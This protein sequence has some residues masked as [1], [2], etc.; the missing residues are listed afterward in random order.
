MKG[1]RAT[2]GRSH[3]S[4][5]MWYDLVCK[6][7]TGKLLGLTHFWPWEMDK[8]LR[9]L[10]HKHEDLNFT[11]IHG[12][13]GMVAPTVGWTMGTGEST[14]MNGSGN[15][16]SVVANNRVCL[17]QGGRQW[18]TLRLSPD[19]CLHLYLHPYSPSYTYIY[20]ELTFNKIEGNRSACKISSFSVYK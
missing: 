1:N 17:E 8:W 16:T 19:T 20:Q 12:K 11:R 14:E 15:L 6:W 9:C 4:I 5:C 2:N 10:P 13:T 18:M 7:H 3:M